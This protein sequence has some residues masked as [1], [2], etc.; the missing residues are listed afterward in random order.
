MRLFFL[1]IFHMVPMPDSD[2]AVDAAHASPPLT[3]VVALGLTPTKATNYDCYDSAIE[4]CCWR[5]LLPFMQHLV[6]GT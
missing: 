2:H 3:G 5:D 4:C 1:E 6:M